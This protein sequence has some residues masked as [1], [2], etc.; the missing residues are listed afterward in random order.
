MPAGSHTSPPVSILLFKH[1]P[2]SDLCSSFEVH[3]VSGL[4]IQRQIAK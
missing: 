4:I 1:R 2:G 3:A